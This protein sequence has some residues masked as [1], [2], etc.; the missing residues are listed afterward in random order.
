MENVNN[1]ILS[2]RKQLLP[3]QFLKSWEGKIKNFPVDK[4]GC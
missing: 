3:F 2:I 4:V 1:I